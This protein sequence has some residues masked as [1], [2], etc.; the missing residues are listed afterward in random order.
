MFI[1]LGFE[2]SFERRGFVTLGIAALCVGVWIVRLANGAGDD[3]GG[4]ALD[5]ENFRVHQLL[6][7]SF[8]HAG[9]FHLAFNLL[10]LWTFGRYVEDRLGEWRFLVVYL[11]CAVVG[12]LAYL[13]SRASTPAVGASGA[14]AGLMGWVLVAAPWTEVR[15]AFFMLPY[16]SRMYELAVG[17][18][19]AGWILLQL[20]LAL[21]GGAGD[22][23]VAA[24][25]GGFAAGAAAGAW[26]RSRLCL[27]TGWYVDPRPP[28]GGPAAVARLRAARARG[29]S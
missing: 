20:A 28:E 9:A 14:I 11:G 26:M 25:L 3:F 23:A 8:L 29:T 18:L 17:W 27:G 22:V 21:F 10:F 19:L 12:D 6:T 2:H 13:A 5:P 15:F 16:A 1:P 7:S 4:C 24:H